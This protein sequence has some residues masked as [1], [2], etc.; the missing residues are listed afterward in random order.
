MTYNAMLM[1][2]A[3]QA[4]RPHLGQKTPHRCSPRVEDLSKP[5]EAGTREIRPGPGAVDSPRWL[6]LGALFFLLCGLLKGKP[7]GK[8]SFFWVPENK[9]THTHTNRPKGEVLRPGLST[10][11]PVAPWVS[12]SLFGW[13]AFREQP[14]S[15][16]P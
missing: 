6:L 12:F 7:K 10:S 15:L 1:E 4:P 11:A 13:F 3:G 2:L 14:A 16:S 5:A 8:P 9:N